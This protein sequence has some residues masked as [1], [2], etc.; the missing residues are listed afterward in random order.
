VLFDQAER[1]CQKR[2]TAL[3]IVIVFRIT[4]TMMLNRLSSARRLN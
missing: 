2:T 3:S 4:A 1:A